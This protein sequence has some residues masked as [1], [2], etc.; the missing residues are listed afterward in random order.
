MGA[1]KYLMCIRYFPINNIDWDEEPILKK[2]VAGNYQKTIIALIILNLVTQV[3]FYG[4]IGYFYAIDSKKLE[5]LDLNDRI[6]SLEGFINDLKNLIPLIFK[7]ELSI[8]KFMNGV[9]D[10]IV[11]SKSFMI[12]AL[13]YFNST[14]NLNY[15]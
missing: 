14:K 15:H 8:G 9:D 6:A 4:C 11:E 7:A 1:F 13:N 12:I 10:Y 2:V 5:D 3:T